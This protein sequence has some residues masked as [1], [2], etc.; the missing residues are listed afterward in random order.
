MK[1]VDALIGHFRLL[2]KTDDMLILSSKIT[3]SMFFKFMWWYD[4]YRL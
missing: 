2:Y 3:F 1:V 4:L